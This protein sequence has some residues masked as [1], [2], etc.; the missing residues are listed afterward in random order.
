MIRF[1]SKKMI[2]LISAWPAIIEVKAIR[3][4]VIVIRISMNI[5]AIKSENIQS[6]IVINADK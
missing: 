5:R 3:R 1:I 6:R 2:F 4:R